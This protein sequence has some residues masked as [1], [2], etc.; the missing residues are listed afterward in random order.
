MFKTVVYS[1]A[2]HLGDGAH[3]SKPIPLPSVVF[4]GGEKSREMG[5]GGKVLCVQMTQSIPIR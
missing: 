4:K 5:G 3:V 1:R 2:G